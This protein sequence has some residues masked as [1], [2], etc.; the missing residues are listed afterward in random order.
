MDIAG[1][2]CMGQQAMKN[3]DHPA[4]GTRHGSLVVI[5]A[6]GRHKNRDRL[7]LCRCDCGE[8]VT[9]IQWNIV[10]GR[11]RSCG[12]GRDGRPPTHGESHSLEYRNWHGMINRCTDRTNQS[13]KHY[14]G[15]GI[16]VCDRWRE[17][18]DKFIS[19]MG[20]RPSP[21]HSVDRI[22]V[23][24]NYE[25]GNC[26]WA[27]AKEQA[28]NKRSNRM[29]AAQGETKTLSEWLMDPRCSVSHQTFYN[30]LKQGFTDA[31][32]ILLPP[33]PRGR[34]CRPMGVTTPGGV[35]ATQ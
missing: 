20:R 33:F 22:D 7:W 2:K 1:K 32:S 6:S 4:P 35:N 23:N 16:T 31:D 15:R 26:R 11:T 21:R 18:P 13:W 8:T 27:T 3:A 30:R 34:S 24:G 29:I 10:C 14:G 25:P 9:V 12:C 5:A 17:S 19:D 28:L